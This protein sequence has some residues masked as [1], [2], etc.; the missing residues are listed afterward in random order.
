MRVSG[1]VLVMGVFLLATQAM[2]SGRCVD[3][4]GRDLGSDPDAYWAEIDKAPS[5]QKARDLANACADADLEGAQTYRR[6]ENVCAAE[7][8]RLNPTDGQSGLF[9]I[10]RQACEDRYRDSSGTM[11]RAFTAS[12]RLEAASWLLEHIVRPVEQ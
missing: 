5:C 4:S 12:C 3:A 1:L 10:M 9:G 7:I 11:Y 6:A 2:A 8:N